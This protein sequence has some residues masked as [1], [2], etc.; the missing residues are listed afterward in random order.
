MAAIVFVIMTLMGAKQTV[1]PTIGISLAVG[2]FFYIAIQ[3]CPV[4]VLRDGLRGYNFWESTGPCGG[5]KSHS[6]TAEVLLAC[7]IWF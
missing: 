3:L 7:R 4:Y 6:F 2:A 5:K 1:L